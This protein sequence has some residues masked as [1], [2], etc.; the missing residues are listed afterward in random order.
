[1]SPYNDLSAKLAD[2]AEQVNGHIDAVNVPFPGKG[3]TVDAANAERAAMAQHLGRLAEW[4]QTASG[5]AST[6]VSYD[7]GLESAP[8]PEEILARR[9]ACFESGN[10][11]EVVDALKDA[12]REK[13]AAQEHHDD[14]TSGTEWG[15]QPAAPK[16]TPTKATIGGDP[17]APSNSGGTL[18]GEGGEDDATEGG[19]ESGDRSDDGS[20]TAAPSASS[21]SG[22]SDTPTTT[23]SAAPVSDSAVSTETSS[24]TMASASTGT[25]TGTLSGATQPQPTPGGQPITGTNM[26]PNAG[27]GPTGGAAGQLGQ[28]PQQARGGQQPSKRGDDDKPAPPTGSDAVAPVVGAVGAT[29]SPTAPHAPTNAPSTAP[30]S[31]AGAQGGTP[32]PGGATANT[33]AANNGAGAG[34]AGGGPMGGARPM[35][36]GNTVTPPVVHRAETPEEYAAREAEL[37]RLLAE[38]DTD[39][40]GTKS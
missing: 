17:N 4:L 36:S 35:G 21:G 14:D 39:K 38:L 24:D 6:Q 7:K 5:T 23:P 13:K 37:D 33:G 28:Q 25:G 12:M 20:H 15:D 16:C 19:E 32:Q 26:P 2:L 18:A 27:Y 9:Q 1:M 34:G 8:S 22:S 29:G 3:A 40:A 31:N 10:A 11:P 30:T